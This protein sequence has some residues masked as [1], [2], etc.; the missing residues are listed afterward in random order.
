MAAT[1]VHS[2]RYCSLA[3]RIAAAEGG[4]ELRIIENDPRT[5]VLEDGR[6]LLELNPLGTVSVLLLESGVVIR[7]TVA[8]L[9]WVQDHAT[10]PVRREPGSAAYYRQLQW[11]CFL[12]TELHT[13]LFRV[14]FYPE[15]T[16]AV[17][18]NFRALTPARL[19]LIEAALGTQAYL[20]DDAWSVADAY[21]TWILT[22]LGRAGVSIESSPALFEYQRRALQRPAVQRLLAD[23]DRRIAAR[24]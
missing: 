2:P 24:G 10:A 23:D 11:L 1:L 17:K 6:S 12:S 19:E 16:D 21:L 5:R 22:L 13:K 15:A 4:V 14:V 7:E 20:V 8:A 18:D 9:L 3:V